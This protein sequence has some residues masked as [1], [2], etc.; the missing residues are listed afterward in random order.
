[1]SS[2]RRTTIT[3]SERDVHLVAEVHVCQ[4]LL[5]DVDPHSRGREV[6]QQEEPA[7]RG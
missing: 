7:L 5:E 6:G 3:S 1:V 4:A 2:S